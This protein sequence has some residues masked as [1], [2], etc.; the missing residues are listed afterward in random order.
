MVRFLDF[1]YR[2]FISDVGL[3]MMKSL[4]LLT[5]LIFVLKFFFLMAILL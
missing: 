4:C 1:V 3:G 2:E 5:S